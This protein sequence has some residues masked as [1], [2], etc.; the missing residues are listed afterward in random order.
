MTPRAS[1]GT[2]PAPPPLS[3]FAEGARSGTGPLSA[4][5]LIVCLDPED[6]TETLAS[7]LDANSIVFD[8]ALTGPEAILGRITSVMQ[9]LSPQP[10]ALPSELE[11]CS[12]ALCTELQSMPRL[13]LV[14]TL[15]ISAHIAVLGACGIPLSRLDFRPGEITHLPDGLLLADGCHFPSKPFP[16]DMMAQRRSALTELS[17]K[18]RA[19]LRPTL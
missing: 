4:E 1:T 7:F 9:P 18:I 16:A 6:A 14:L 10:L 13:K 5:M 11:A 17:P 3:A 2:I 15:G 8:P 12:A 19:A